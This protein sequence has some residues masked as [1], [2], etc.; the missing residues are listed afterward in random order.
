MRAFQPSRSAS[1]RR[2]GWAV[3]AVGI[4]LIVGAI[5]IAWLNPQ[6]TNYIESDRFRG[7]LE[8][9][10]GKGLHFPEGH[11]APIHRKGFLGAAADR[12]KADN[13]RKALRAIDAHGITARLNPWGVFLRRWQL[14][15]VH[16]DS[17]EVEIQTYTP[18]PEPS[19]AKP[20]F[21]VFLPQ[22]VYL[23]QVEANPADVT[24]HFRGEKGGFFGTDLVITPHGRDFNYQAS[25]GTLK[26]A[27]IPNLRLRDTHLLV[28]RKLLTLY[29]LDLQS[30]GDATGSIHAEGT[31]GTGEDRSVDFNFSFEHFPIQEWLPRQW[32]E[33]VRGKASG[34]ILWR[35]KNPKLESSAGEATLRV[36]GGSIIELPFLENLAKITNEKA[37]ERLTLSDCSFAVEWNYPKAEVKDIAIEQRGKFRAEGTIQVEKKALSGAIELGVTRHLLDWLAKPE[38]VFPRQHDGYLWT[39]VHLSGTTDAPQQDLS[40]RIM[41]VL[42]ENPGTALGL[43][44]RQLGEWL[45]NAFGGE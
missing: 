26:M 45:K 41:E 31:A 9:E 20:W 35:G 27:L 24:W 8:K 23:K 19:P 21:H 44:L 40:P 11:Y 14:D 42:K 10:T 16:I 32:R 4:L 12:F 17:G 2:K 13:G 38:E 3:A 1:I 28:T 39:T 25:A 22:R 34:K 30:D 33:R 7:E 29:N 43:L 15:D 37:L 6:L 36:D 5:G 18:R